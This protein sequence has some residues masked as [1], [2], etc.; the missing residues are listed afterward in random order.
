MPSPKCLVFRGALINRIGPFL[1]KPEKPKMFFAAVV[2][3]ASG[4]FVVSIGLI[5][6]PVKKSFHIF[7]CNAF[8]AGMNVK[9]VG[10]GRPNS[11]STVKKDSRFLGNEGF[12]FVRWSVHTQG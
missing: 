11:T 4:P 12:L 7:L 2:W 10:V 3:L 1:A 5:P 9:T 8:H 6:G